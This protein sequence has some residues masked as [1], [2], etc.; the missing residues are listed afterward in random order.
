MQ[1]QPHS[2]RPPKAVARQLAAFFNRNGYVRRQNER[3]LKEEGPDRYKKGEEVRLIA[4]S[5]DELEL[6]RGLLE[7]AGFKPGRPFEKGAQY[8]QPIY[9]RQ[10]VARFLQ[11]VNDE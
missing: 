5:T 9:G 3:R 7:R 11:M 10:A 4:Q 2:S 8:C 1:Q 6:M